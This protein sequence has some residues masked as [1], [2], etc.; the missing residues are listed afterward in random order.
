[1]ATPL[2]DFLDHMR[3]WWA[4][5]MSLSENQF[6]ATTASEAVAE[7]DAARQ[8]HS[9]PDNEDE[10]WQAKFESLWVLKDKVDLSGAELTLLE[11]MIETDYV[12]AGGTLPL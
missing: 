5:L 1:M 8:S 7:V 9:F 10:G 12:L 3:D 4:L 6:Q 2:D 11:G